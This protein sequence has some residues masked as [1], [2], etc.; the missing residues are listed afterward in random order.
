MEE[1]R[2]QEDREHERLL[3]QVMV[4]CRAPPQ[5][6]LYT[7][8]DFPAHHQ[9]YHCSPPPSFPRSPQQSP[10]HKLC[11]HMQY[12]YMSLILR[13]VTLFIRGETPLPCINFK[14]SA[15]PAELPQWL[16]W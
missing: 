15:C 12:M 1:R 14:D 3:V 13:L 2:S 9:G 6:S 8:Y 11:I 5:P 16:S 7:P 4:Q 10:I